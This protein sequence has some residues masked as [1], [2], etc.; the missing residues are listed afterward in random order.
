MSIEL[1]NVQVTG[2]ETQIQSSIITCMRSKRQA[3]LARK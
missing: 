2:M 3:Y 1:I